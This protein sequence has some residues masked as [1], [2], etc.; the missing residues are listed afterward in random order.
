MVVFVGR[1]D[2]IIDNKQAAF[3]PVELLCTLSHEIYHQKF[4]KSLRETFQKKSDRSL[5]FD[6]TGGGGSSPDPLKPNPYFDCL[7]SLFLDLPRLN[8]NKL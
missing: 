1:L 7:S 4:E 5:G 3:G 6:Q 8:N 2:M